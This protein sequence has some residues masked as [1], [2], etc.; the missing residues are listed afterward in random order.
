MVTS[1]L[2]TRIKWQNQSNSRVREVGL[3]YGGRNFKVHGMHAGKRIITTAIFF[4]C[5]PFAKASTCNNSSPSRGSTGHF[6][7]SC[8]DSCLCFRPVMR[9]FVSVP[10]SHLSELPEA[11]KILTATL[12]QL[13]FLWLLSPALLV[14]HSLSRRLPWTWVGGVMLHSVTQ[15]SD[16]KGMHQS[17]SVCSV[18]WMRG[19]VGS[20]DLLPGFLWTQEVF[21]RRNFEGYL[22]L[23]LCVRELDHTP[24][25]PITCHR[26]RS[27]GDICISD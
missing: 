19:Y 7:G 13:A 27:H 2:L 5:K 20:V 25:Y 18:T 15:V 22:S 24:K 26:R 14:A 9:S 8:S 16:S 10:R 11:S 17:C 23:I 3:T 1:W 12:T 4:I 6:P 21:S